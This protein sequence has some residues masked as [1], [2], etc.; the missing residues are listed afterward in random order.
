MIKEEISL[1]NNFLFNLFE[2][3]ESILIVLL[4]NN[5][6]KRDIGYC[7][8]RMPFNEKISLYNK[9]SYHLMQTTTA[10]NDNNEGID[11]T[12]HDRNE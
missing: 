10:G 5:I 6:S 11:P 7:A 8:T 4:F 9:R 1:G 12:N 3:P 2:I